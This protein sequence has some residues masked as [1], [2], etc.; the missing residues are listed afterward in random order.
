MASFNIVVALP[1]KN[2]EVESFWSLL[3]QLNRYTYSKSIFT[4]QGTMIKAKNGDL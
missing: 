2:C 1:K 4:I 3:S